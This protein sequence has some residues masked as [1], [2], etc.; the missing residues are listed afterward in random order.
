M[1]ILV[2][3]LHSDGLEY[4][5]M[6]KHHMENDDSIFLTY[7]ENIEE[8]VKYSEQD[9]LFE[10][11]GKNTYVPGLL[12]KT[13]KALKY[14]IEKSDFDF[15]VRTNSS[16]V[17]DMEELKK[18]L[19]YLSSKHVYGGHVF[20]A[21]W[22]NEVGGIT[23]N[24]FE[25]IK[26]TEFVSGTSMIMSKSVCEYILN[27]EQLLDYSI[28]DDVAIGLLLKNIGGPNV[29]LP[30][31]E[32][33]TLEPNCCFYRFK[34]DNRIQD[35]TNILKQYSLLKHKTGNNMHSL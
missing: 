31:H 4:D 22:L 2:L 9:K 8:D 28:V 18:K 12:E 7:N 16:T 10:I 13:V 3:R 32:G 6:K 25:R 15:V 14:F 19:S 5:E 24:V 26:D 20:R 30:F 23:P 29:Y 11:K 1:K 27:N 17:I 33:V 34:S 21:I 35:I